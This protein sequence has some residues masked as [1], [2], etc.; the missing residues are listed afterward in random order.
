VDRL[1]DPTL[2]AG[3]RVMTTSSMQSSKKATDPGS[4]GQEE[5]RQALRLAGLFIVLAGI[6]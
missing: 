6:R 3:A 1:R 2:T 5:P 4:T